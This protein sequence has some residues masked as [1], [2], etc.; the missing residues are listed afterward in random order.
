VSEAPP[1]TYAALKVASEWVGHRY[2]IEHGLDFVAIR[3]AGVFGPWDGT[4][5]SPNRLIQTL[6]E[7]AQ[8]GRTCRMTR[9]EMVKEGS[10]Y[11]YAPDAGRAAVRAAFAA[12]PD[13]RV[14]NI[15]MGRAYRV[16]EIINIVERVVGQN[17]TIDLIEGRPL[18]GYRENP[19]VLDISRARAELAYEVQFPMERAIKDYVEKLDPGLL[20]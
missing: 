9:D 1:S 19:G 6:I 12:H 13:S 4:L 11:V 2:R 7:S 10:D 20:R 15:A 8:H 18:S 16:Q 3:L 14:Y 5:S 17:I